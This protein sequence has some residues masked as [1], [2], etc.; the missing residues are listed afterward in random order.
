MFGA[1]QW[2]GWYFNGWRPHLP[3]RDMHPLVAANPQLSPNDRLWQPAT[4]SLI[5]GQPIK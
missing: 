5:A 3:A 4:A 2:F 1:V